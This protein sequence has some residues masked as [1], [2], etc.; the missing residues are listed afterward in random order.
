MEESKI[1]TKMKL[2]QTKRKMW[3]KK[4]TMYGID[5]ILG[6]AEETNG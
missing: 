6:T 5:N 3:E 1:S 2:L 4:N